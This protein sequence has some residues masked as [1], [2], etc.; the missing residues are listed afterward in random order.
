[1]NLQIA[2][3]SHYRFARADRSKASPHHKQLNLYLWVGLGGIFGTFARYE[4]ALA[5]P[6]HEGSIPWATFAV[7]VAGSFILGALIETLIRSGRDIGLRRRMRLL[8]GTGF[9]GS[10]TTISTFATETDLLIKGDHLAT[11]VLYLALTTAFGLDAAV[12]GIKVTAKSLRR[13]ETNS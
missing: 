13:S 8:I 7:N 12:V 10:L 2:K 3:K 5:T 1:M 6:A 4:I 9:C 11:A